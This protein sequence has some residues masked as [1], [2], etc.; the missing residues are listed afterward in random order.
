MRERGPFI[1]KRATAGDST[2]ADIMANKNWR[3]N[4]RGV[5]REALDLLFEVITPYQWGMLLKAPLLR[6]VADGNR[7][8]VQELA[9]AGAEFGSALHEAVL[10]GYGDMVNDL[11]AN[12]A[13]LNGKEALERCQAYDEELFDDTCKSPLHV[14]V[15]AGKMAMV[16]LLL[17]KGANKDALDTEKLTPLSLAARCWRVDVDIMRV[18]IEHGADVN[19][20]GGH[21]QRS[22]L[23]V[24][25]GNNAVAAVHVLV[26]AGA[27]IDARD[28]TGATPLHYAAGCFFL[29]AAAA[30]CH[31]GT[32]INAR[33][34]RQSTPLHVAAAMA[35]DQGTAN[36]VD[37]LLRSGADETIVDEDG[38]AAVDVV[39]QRHQ[40]EEDCYY[41][42]GREVEAEHLELVRDLLANAPA[43][44]ADRALRLRVYLVLCRAHPD[45]MQQAHQSRSELIAGPRGT[46]RDT[47]AQGT[48]RG[49]GCGATGGRT[50][51]NRTGVDWEDVVARVV[52]LQEEGIFRAIV[53]YL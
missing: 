52:G 32:D 22:V 33:D 45:R 6:A 53:G 38:K 10:R 47:V 37:F 25:A 4:A 1:V 17:L 36:M 29:E 34:L 9:G 28:D 8:L 5:E 19:H 27:H 2:A 11:L 18:L 49:R 30:L 13:P 12:G 50:V 48:E 31:H 24:A 7:G 44:R 16:K 35:G 23:H 46:R 26:E 21:N 15:K 42:D 40:F 20:A 14:A 39:R 41:E 3:E 51:K 43:D